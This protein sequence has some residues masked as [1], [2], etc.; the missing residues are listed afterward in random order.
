MQADGVPTTT[1][2]AFQSP[3]NEMTFLLKAGLN[4]GS[5]LLSQLSLD[6]M[7]IIEIVSIFESVEPGKVILFSIVFQRG[8]ILVENLETSYST[9][10]SK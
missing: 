8:I 9:K 6:V 3:S 4:F 2:M 10:F 7:S 5:A 1:T